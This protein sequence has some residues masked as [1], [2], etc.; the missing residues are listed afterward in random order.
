M[1]DKFQLNGIDQ[2]NNLAGDWSLQA[3]ARRTYIDR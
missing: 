3:V 2:V 1:R